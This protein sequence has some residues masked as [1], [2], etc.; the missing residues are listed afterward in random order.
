MSMIQEDFRLSYE[1]LKLGSIKAWGFTEVE[2]KT[3][4]PSVKFRATNIEAK[5]DKAVGVREVETIVDFQVSTT[6]IEEAIQLTESIRALRAQKKPIHLMG[7]LP[8]KQGA[9]EI[10]KIKSTEPLEDFIKR[11]NI[12]FNTQKNNEKK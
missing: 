10:L 4:P 6:T 9:D 7:G 11:N 2:G 12:V 3:Y 8:N 5:E 1:I